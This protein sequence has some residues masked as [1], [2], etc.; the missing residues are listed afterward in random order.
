MF[1]F[2]VPH[3]FQMCLKINP[4]PSKT[5][6]KPSQ[7]LPRTLPKP[8]KIDPKSIQKASWS[9]SWTHVGKK[10]DLKKQKT[11]PEAPKSAQETPKTV[12][13]PPKWSPRPSQIHVLSK[14]SYFF[15]LLKTWMVFYRFLLDLLLMFRSP[16]LIKHSKNNGFIDVLAKSQF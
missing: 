14:F 15:C 12:P 8:P 7:N 2:L 13:T 4:N 3:S 11:G 6:P 9:P 1:V 5:A 16:T 10:C